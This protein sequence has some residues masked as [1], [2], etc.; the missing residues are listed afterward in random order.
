MKHCWWELGRRLG[1]K[2]RL[3][4][5]KVRVQFLALHDAAHDCL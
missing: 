1:S 4:L 5:Y 2:E 3:L